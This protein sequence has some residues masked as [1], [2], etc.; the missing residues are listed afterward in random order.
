MAKNSKLAGLPGAKSGP[1]KPDYVP[2]ETWNA[3]DDTQKAYMSDPANEKEIREA[4]APDD[5]G[6]PEQ[7]TTDDGE[8]VSVAVST[9][10]I[11][12][13]FTN[14]TDEL[15]GKISDKDR[16]AFVEAVEMEMTAKARTVALFVVITRAYGEGA[17]SLPRYGSTKETANLYDVFTYKKKT[18]KGTFSKN[19][20]EGSVLEVTAYK[21]MI[22]TGMHNEIKEIEKKI[23][24]MGKDAMVPFA[25]QTR[26][27]ELRD[28]RNKL[29][30]KFIFAVRLV[31]VLA[32]IA[33]MEK[34]G[35]SFIAND[36]STDVNDD[37]SN[38]TLAN[39]CVLLFAKNKNGSRGMSVA[40]SPNVIVDFR[41]A[42]AIEAGGT[43][44]N[45]LLSKDEG[46]PEQPE[47]EKDLEFANWDDATRGLAGIYTF[48]NKFAG[49]KAS[50]TDAKAF[51]SYLLSDAGSRTLA[52]IFSTVEM[53]EESVTTQPELRAQE[54]R[55]RDRIN[56]EMGGDAN[57]QVKQVA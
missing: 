16:E 53:F 38:L 47:S 48:W 13:S 19:E 5:G 39:S 23:S 30:K 32:D 43:L 25:Y 18:S 20:S 10:D 15:S 26:L 45:L 3:A 8:R 2:D 17:A 1:V 56:Q 4:F 50:K 14:Q 41:P 52:L 33:A 24:A 6:T 9:G 21:A 54:K 49:D 35:W 46:T 51:R 36:G 22:S 28:K 44:D 37:L 12:T 31:H 7:K 42:K 29:I 55:N 34:C 40:L 57:R 27:E 11:P